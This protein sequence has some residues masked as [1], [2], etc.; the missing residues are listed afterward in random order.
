M[1]GLF[2]V[3]ERPWVGNGGNAGP[4]GANIG[5]GGGGGCR[6]VLIRDVILKKKS[7]AH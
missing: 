7:V 1:C 3:Q 4:P 5:E 2:L 6:A